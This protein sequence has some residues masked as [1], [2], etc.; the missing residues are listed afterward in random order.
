M[1]DLRGAVGRLQEIL[2]TS[3]ERVK[4][5]LKEATRDEANRLADDI[6]RGMVAQT[7]G[8][9]GPPLLPISDFNK[10]MRRWRNVAGDLVLV[11]HGE[12]FD[13]I[14][15][16]DAGGGAY[17]AGILPGKVRRQQNPG[18]SMAALAQIQENG[19]VLK[20]GLGVIVV[21]PRPFIR[22]A[23]ERWRSQPLRIGLGYLRGLQKALGF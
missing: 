21:P 22:P 17:E 15:V 18:F 7:S 19:A 4:A 9:G 16:V 2:S 1:I 13:S 8:L 10:V 12:L 3:A 6:R 14:G 20:S 5:T 11:S 23:F